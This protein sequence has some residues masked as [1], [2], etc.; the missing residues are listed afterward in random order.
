MAEA[1]SLTSGRSG[2]RLRISCTRIALF[3]LAS[4]APAQAWFAP[5]GEASFGV[6]YQNVY[7]RDRLFSE[8]DKI[9]GAVR[10]VPLG[11]SS[12]DAPSIR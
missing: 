5:Q 7:T 4:S 9:E 8:G 10:R 1:A 2:V 11:L 3:F 12:E 6:A